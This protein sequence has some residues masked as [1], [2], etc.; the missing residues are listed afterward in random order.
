MNTDAQR[1][2]GAEGE[3][4]EDGAK[5]P[6]KRFSS[7]VDALCREIGIPADPDVVR[8]F[9][10][11]EVGG[12]HVMVTHMQADEQAMYLNFCFSCVSPGRTLGVFRAML[13]S[14]FTV[15]GQDQ[16]QLGLQP[17][18]GSVLLIVRVPMTEEIDGAYLAET[19]QHYSE[20]GRYWVETLHAVEDEMYLPSPFSPEPFVWIK[21]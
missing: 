16:A 2:D 20:H 12:F 15:Y 7:L 14:N 11:I 13:Q 9:G 21:A 1:E 3:E 4:D 19:I 6:A 17:D 5:K 10:M 8:D 18:H